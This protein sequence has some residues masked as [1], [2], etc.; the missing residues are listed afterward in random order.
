[1]KV[2]D[3]FVY[4]WSGFPSNWTKCEI[5]IESPIDHSKKQFHSSEQLF[6]YYKAIFFNDHETADKILNCGRDP[7]KAK[8]LGRQVKNFN[9]EAWN[10][11]RLMYMIKANMYKYTQNEELKK[12]LLSDKYKGKSFVEASPVDNIWGIGIHEDDASDDTSNWKG[13]NLLGKALDTVRMR[14][15]NQNGED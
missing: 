11:V 14:I 6:M 1:M 8:E 12:L 15:L 7:K 2:T 13:Q 5:T 3:K 9:N 4:F 10:G